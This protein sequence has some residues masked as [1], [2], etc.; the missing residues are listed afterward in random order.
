MRKLD[1]CPSCGEDAVLSA[2]PQSGVR[3]SEP[4]CATCREELIRDLPMD[5]LGPGVRAVAGKR[6]GRLRGHHDTR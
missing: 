6:L 5:D 3:F 4:I 2:A 1:I